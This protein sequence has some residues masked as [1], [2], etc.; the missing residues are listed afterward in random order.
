MNKEIISELN[1]IKSLMKLINEQGS[2][3]INI[4]R[5]NQQQLADAP[6]TFGPM[7]EYEK[8]EVGGNTKYPTILGS[9]SKT[10][11]M[12]NPN[13]ILKQSG[14][15]TKASDFIPNVKVDE[16][17][18]EYI[19]RNGK[20]YC[21]PDKKFWDAFN[22]KNYVY[23]I[24]NPRNN[25]KFSMRLTTVGSV[26]VPT[27]D[28]NG[29]IITQELKGYEA[30]LKCLG[31]DN[32]WG[33]D[34]KNGSIFW[35]KEGD[36]YESYNTNNPEHFDTRSDFDVWWDKWGVFVEIGLGLLAAWTGAGLAASLIR[37]GLFANTGLASAYAAGN[38]T[39][40]SV[41]L[42]AG[43]EAGLMAPIASYQF[44]RDQD[45]NAILTIAF[46]FLPFLTE[47]GSVQKFIKGGIQP[48][49]SKSLGSKF[50]TA[51]GESAFKN[52]PTAYGNFLESLTVSELML[53]KTTIDQF[54]TKEGQKTFSDALGKYLKENEIRLTNE[55]LGNKGWTEQLDDLT[56]GQFSKGAKVL[57]KQNPIKGTG[58][59]AQFIRVGLPLA[60][61]AI[62]FQK[63]Y[64]TLKG[65]GYSDVQIEKIT[66]DVKKS[67][68]LSEFFVKIAKLNND[69]Y[70][71]LVNDVLLEFVSKKE[72]LEKILNGVSEDGAEL[73]RIAENK[74]RN[75][76]EY[77]I[78]LT[79]LPDQERL[80]TS[81]KQR[82]VSKLLEPK[83]FTNSEI[84]DV[85]PLEK[86]NFT[87]DENKSGE[88]VVNKKILEPSD[89]NSIDYDNDFNLNVN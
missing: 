17:G 41:I 56:A 4:N 24:V 21:L 28:D 69:L 54:S 26:K 64:D 35:T 32:G 27:M 89:I 5:L 48:E 76:E 88:I 83:G 52:N 44:S 68:D 53:W 72:N 30:A 75:N 22:S 49:V 2:A 38:T 39:W 15:G 86:Y 78:L 66:N 31:G 11:V 13:P 25:K 55:I 18:N 80:N 61:V 62:G 7:D 33:W 71:K 42:Q 81:L 8:I 23:Q 12:G 82:I 59:L 1:R 74:I 73:V 77:Q 20:K 37:L 85:I 6:D 65:H 47:L 50:L 29:N 19:E 43:V 45:S 34:I 60:G 84:T 46:S 16:K 87:S 70:K 51:G 10:F 67:I 58:L 63:I 36:K 40:L 9:E 3:D 79:V 14:S 57:L